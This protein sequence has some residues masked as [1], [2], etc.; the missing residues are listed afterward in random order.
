M[1]IHRFPI[2][3]AGF[4]VVVFLLGFLAATVGFSGSVAV[5]QTPSHEETLEKM[6]DLAGVEAGREVL[7]Y[8]DYYKYPWKV[9]KIAKDFQLPDLWEFPILADPDQN[10]DFLFFIEVLRRKDDLPWRSFLSLRFLM[11]GFLI[12]LREILGKIFS[13][14]T[15]VNVL[16]IP[17]SQ[18]ISV[19]ER[20][21]EKDLEQNLAG[22]LM[23]EKTDN[24][25]S[26]FR[27]VY[28]FEREALWELSINPVHILMHFGESCGK[29]ILSIQENHWW[30]DESQ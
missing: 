18:E 29:C 27:L 12:T 9:H 25:K 16:P 28:M 8:K 22:K 26:G 19:K 11:A 2:R 1:G 21:F 6:M 10:Q 20:L 23:A 14:D 17:E 7:S 13:L 4:I 3:I 30:M 24:G 5:C 15:H